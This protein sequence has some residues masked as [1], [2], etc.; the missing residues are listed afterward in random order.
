MQQTTIAPLQHTLSYR[1]IID[2]DLARGSSVKLLITNFGQLGTEALDY[3][4]HR[5]SSRAFFPFIRVQAADLASERRLLEH[6]CC[7]FLDQAAGGTV[8]IS[9][10]DEMAPAVQELFLDLVQELELARSPNAAVRLVAGT[11]VPLT[12]R[13][14]AGKFSQR[15]FYRLNTIHLLAGELVRC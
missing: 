9:D 3:R 5:G 8:L 10:V 6:T 7:S 12:D 1:D 11:T 2:E 14:A 15:L 13:I 4:I